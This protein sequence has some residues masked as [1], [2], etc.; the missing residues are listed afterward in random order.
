[1][2]KA[3]LCDI[4]DKILDNGPLVSI[5]VPV[6]NTPEGPL[7]RC[8]RSLFAQDY[9]NVE[10]IIV[11]DGSAESCRAVLDDVLSSEPRTR[12]IAGGHRGVSHA[13]NVGI[14]AAEGEW[15][16]FSD[17]DDEVEPC[18]ISDALKVALAEGADFVCGSVDWL[19]QDSVPNRGAYSQEYY[20]VDEKHGLTSAGMQMLG[21]VKYKNFT[22]PDF[23]GRGPVA[24]LYKL[25]Q[26]GDLRFDEGI[27][28]GEDTLFNY[29]YIERCQ[30]MAIVNAL[31]YLYYQYEDSASHSTDST[32]WKNSIEGILANRNEGESWVPFD[33]R[34]SFMSAQAVE[35]LARSTNVFN[36][37]ARGAELLDFA[38]DHGCFSGG[39]FEG[40]ELS[41]WFARFIH[42][43]KKGRHR[44]ASWFWV[45]KTLAKDR[46]ANRKLI[47]PHSVPVFRKR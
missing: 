47:D 12:V 43:C 4:E 23:K 21:P 33:S 9:R 32:P 28:I 34:C 40:Y 2:R 10:F 17:A 15:I 19:F 30:S 8:L 31:W 41:P 18:F 38:S 6:Y 37:G 25:T 20:V 5:I 11:D 7:R 27:P 1:M 46:L 36:A 29:R 13:R 35:V 45:V 26:L 42:L 44:R 14:V 3:S 22:G 39:C 24:K 16:A